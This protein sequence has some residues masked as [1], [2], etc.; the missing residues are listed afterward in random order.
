MGCLVGGCVVVGRGVVLV[1]VC[2][3]VG[4]WCVVSSGVAGWWWVLGMVGCVGF[5]WGGLLGRCGQ[6]GSVLIA[7][8]GMGKS[9]ES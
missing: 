4:V 7:E 1:V 2:F 8:S 3:R 9:P 5:V 6:V